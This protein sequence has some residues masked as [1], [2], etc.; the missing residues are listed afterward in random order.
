MKSSTAFSWV[1]L[2]FLALVW[3]SSFILM[4][5]GMQTSDGTPIYSDVQVGAL[6][7]TIA[8]IVMFP[9]GI[10]LIKKIK[11]L[12][13]FFALLIVGTCG[14]F[15]PA[16]LFTYAET[17][18]SS[19]MAGMLNSFTSF[20][21]IIIGYLIFKQ[22]V[23]KQQVF[24]LLIAFAGIF[25]LVGNSVLDGTISWPHIGAVI[26]ATVLYATSL[27]TIK[28]E[29]Q[30]LK[31]LEITALAFT[32]VAIPALVVSYFSGAFVVLTKNT[33]G[34]SGLGYIAILSLVGTCLAVI[35]FNRIIAL[36]SAVFA[37]SVTYFIPIVAVIIGCF[38]N[39]EIILWQQVLGMV[40]I[41]GGVALANSWKKK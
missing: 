7:M 40:V 14:N 4:L 17:G 18:V 22:T 25:L 38:L 33:N 5:R 23:S 3:G 36:K 11:T 12:R 13:L 15:I 27:N 34:L 35:L 8:G 31:S 16:F 32:L 37:S 21:T 19:G 41:I 2:V 24:G 6:R 26:L 20:F 28:H 39:K 9:F 29:C 1:L 30:G 10:F